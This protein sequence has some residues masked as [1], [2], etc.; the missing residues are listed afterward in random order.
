MDKALKK[1][2]TGETAQRQRLS[3][4]TTAIRIL[5]AFSDSY[6]EMGISSLAKRI[7]V[8]KSTV[9]RIVTTMVAEGLLEQNPETDRYYLGIGLFT[10]GTLVRRRMSVSSEAKPFLNQLRNTANENV[11]LAVLQESNIIYVHDMESHQTVRIRPHVGQI[12]PAFCS[13][14]GLAILAFSPPD[15]VE[16]VLNEPKKMRTNRTVVDL[17]K[18]YE[19]L[20]KIRS[21]GFAVEYQESEIGL[22]AIAAPIFDAEGQP[23]GAVGL[24]G[25]SERMVQRVVT[26][27]APSVRQTAEMISMRLGYQPTITSYA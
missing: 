6:G 8:S 4:V 26:K 11:R 25:P 1:T 5:K 27:L 18:I 19:N 15:L 24:A 3:S 2:G 10:L 22:H 13:A 23:V 17:P 9:H 16:R 7:G 21:E 20:Q 14:E 12:K